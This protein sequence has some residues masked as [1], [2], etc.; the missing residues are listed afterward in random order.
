MRSETVAGR[1]GGDELEGVDGIVAPHLPVSLAQ[2]FLFTLLKRDVARV[3]LVARLPCLNWPINLVL[4]RS[5]KN[6]QYY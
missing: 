6:T 4:L 1:R 2:I 5:C 3:A